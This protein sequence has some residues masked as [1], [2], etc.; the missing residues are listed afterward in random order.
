MSASIGSELEKLKGLHR[1]GVLSDQEF[2]TAKTKLLGTLGPDHNVGTGVNQLG[3]AANRWVDFNI[4]T[5]LVG[6][7]AAG[8][9]LVFFIIP[10]WNDMQQKRQEFDA[11][12]KAAE[13]RIERAHQEMAE[14]R[15]QFDKDFEKKSKEIEDFRKKNFPNQ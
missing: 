15:K 1:D 5:Y 4:A 11:S 10:M 3:R 14:H 12:F 2:E 7:V 13:Q 6:A 9:V 8:L